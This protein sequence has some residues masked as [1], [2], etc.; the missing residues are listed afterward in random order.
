MSGDNHSVLVLDTVVIPYSGSVN[1]QYGSNITFKN[2]I[3]TQQSTTTNRMTFSSLTSSNIVFDGGFLN[4]TYYYLMQFS[5]GMYQGSSLW[6]K[7][8]V[9]VRSKY[10]TSAYSCLLY[11]SDAADEEDSGDLG[12]RRFIKKQTAL[13]RVFRE[14]PP[15]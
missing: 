14:S 7:N 8:M 15:Q 11:T 6:M 2:F 5:G 9:A 3:Y 1:T 10:F 12:G 4:T 13:N